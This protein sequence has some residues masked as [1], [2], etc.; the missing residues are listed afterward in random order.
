MHFSTLPD[1]RAQRAP[2]APAIHPDAG[3]DAGI[4]RPGDNVL[5]EVHHEIGDVEAA[6][7][8]SAVT[9]EATYR[10]QRLSHMA[11]ETHGAIAWTDDE[12]RFVV[13]SST[14]VP[15]L[16]R[17]ALSEIFDLDPDRVRVY[18]ERVGGGFGGKQEVLCED[19]AL[20]ATMATGRPV[21]TRSAS[22]RCSNASAASRPASA[23]PSNWPMRRIAAAT[24]GRR[25]TSMISTG[26]CN[27]RNRWISD[28][29]VPPP[30]PS[31]SVGRS[32][33]IC[34]SLNWNASPTEG[35][36]RITGGWSE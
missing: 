36:P 20:L 21:R 13:R 33:R 8:A 28:S 4:A 22:S 27:A 26:S 17:R 1:E 5:A 15:F 19:V 30:Q 6:L 35:K 11:L 12:G 3:P 24:S 23:R 25:W 29:G 34:S 16:V 9:H 32:V 31:T 7:A 18:C 2:D 10:T 14:Q